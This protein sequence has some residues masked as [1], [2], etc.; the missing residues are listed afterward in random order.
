M[1]FNNDEIAELKYF[2]RIA[3]VLNTYVIKFERDP[4]LI[5]LCN[6]M[7]F[8]I[9]SNLDLFKS[10]ISS[11]ESIIEVS[12]GQLT[13]LLSPIEAFEEKLQKTLYDIT[14]E[15][16]DYP[17]YF[18]TLVTDLYEFLKILRE[19]EATNKIYNHKNSGLLSSRSY[20][21]KLYSNLEVVIDDLDNR[22]FLFDNKINYHGNLNL[23]NTI[24]VLED[25]LNNLS[26]KFDIF[27]YEY[28]RSKDNNFKQ[29]KDFLEKQANDVFVK[30]KEFINDLRSQYKTDLD[31]PITELKTKL[32]NNKTDLDSLLGDVKLYQDK[33]TNKAVSE[34]SA[35]YFD[36][37]KFERNSYFSITLVSAIIIIFSVISA[38][39]G[40][41]SYYNEYVSTESCDSSESRTIKV[42]GAIK[43]M[44]FEECMKDLS[45]KREATQKY[46]F[47]Y[48]IFRLSFSLLL[49]L[50]VIYASRIAMR[51][52]NHW[53]QSE[54]MYLKL[55][56]LSPFIGSLDK[57]VRNDVHLSLVPDYFGKDAGM[58]ESSKDAVKDIPTNISNIAIKAIEQAGST[59]GSKL[60]SDKE[61]KN[62]DS[63][64]S[65]EKNK[66]KSADDPE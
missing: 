40:V 35:H 66:K 50:A 10:I 41:N 8:D 49:F 11:T 57:S 43:E 39:K 45:V 14:R 2:K 47:N 55:N 13:S 21:K 3:F 23:N 12:A 58:V 36:K 38:Y 60:G 4:V 19:W 9:K 34:M 42:N 30:Y 32:E 31:A 5:N 54:N 22:K 28:T 20:F 27:T 25:R 46:A 37:S 48:L 63:E 6:D 61:S 18:K 53:R 33:M 16:K 15:R 59:I 17:L 56:T 26:K 24:V 52:Y 7:N 65:T 1:L 29:Q 51:A 44:S 62:S 64:S